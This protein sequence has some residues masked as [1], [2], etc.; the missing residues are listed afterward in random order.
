MV[1]TL[2][3]FF[4][5]FLLTFFVIM[6]GEPIKRKK[7]AACLSSQLSSEKWDIHYASLSAMFNPLHSITNQELFEKHLYK[8]S[9]HYK[10]YRQFPL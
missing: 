2:A 10:K 4:C 1:P 9:S 6:T 8:Q 5:T 3:N 7:G